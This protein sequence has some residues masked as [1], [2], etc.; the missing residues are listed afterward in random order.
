MKIPT[1][2]LVV[3]LLLECAGLAGENVRA[4]V[5]IQEQR[6][7]VAVLPQD[8]NPPRVFPLKDRYVMREDDTLIITFNV[9][10]PADSG[11]CIE[12]PAWEIA[13]LSPDFATVTPTFGRNFKH[14]GN[15]NVFV[16]QMALLI[17]S[18]K[19]GDAGGYDIKVWER[20]CPSPPGT[21]TLR[22]F[23]VKVKKK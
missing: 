17:I 11:S 18:P 19:Q 16:H 10:Y 9:I 3:V 22:T 8:F 2:A 5:S 1:I 20:I 14:P 21:G 7:E 15:D 23:R 6:D 13:S 12:T 4:E